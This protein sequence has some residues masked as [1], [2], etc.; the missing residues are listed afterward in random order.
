MN[1]N[2]GDVVSCRGRD[3]FGRYAVVDHCAV[4][5]RD[6]SRNNGMIKYAVYMIMR[7]GMLRE[8]MVAEML[9]TNEPVTA[10]PQVEIGGRADAM[11]MKRKPNAGLKHRSRRQRRPTAIIVGRAPGHP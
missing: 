11:V 8:M 5:A 4:I 2:P 10:G 3:A 7:Q 9:E 6:A 1:G